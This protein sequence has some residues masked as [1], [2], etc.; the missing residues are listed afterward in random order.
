MV[1]ANVT[2]AVLVFLPRSVEI[3]V[4]CDVLEDVSPTQWRKAIDGKW[5]RRGGG[6][7]DVRCNCEFA[8]VFDVM[9]V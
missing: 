1:A 5:C 2:K 9:T 6:D 4:P 3:D 8:A 7:Y